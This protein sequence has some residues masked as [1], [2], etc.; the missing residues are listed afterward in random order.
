[1]EFRGAVEMPLS[2]VGVPV[3]TSCLQPGAV[4]QTGGGGGE[5]SRTWVPASHVGDRGWIRL[6]LQPSPD[7]PEHLE[8]VCLCVSRIN[9][10]RVLCFQ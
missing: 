8:L 6:W 2:R 10:Q 1:M 9:R 5:G 7:V 4:M 3:F